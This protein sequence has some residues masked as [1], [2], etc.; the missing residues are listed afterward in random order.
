MRQ[1]GQD[2]RLSRKTQFLLLVLVILCT[3]L[4]LL[5]SL[6]GVLIVGNIQTSAPIDFVLHPPDER[7][8]GFLPWSAVS[9]SEDLILVRSTNFSRSSLCDHLTQFSLSQSSVKVSVCRYQNR[10]RVD[11]RE[12]IGANATIKGIWL[13]VHE[14]DQLAGTFSLISKAVLLQQLSCGKD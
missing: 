5:L 6:T 1:S 7:N 12:F 4:P 3:A 14:W 9:A 11:I 8:E 10:T 13:N 2:Y